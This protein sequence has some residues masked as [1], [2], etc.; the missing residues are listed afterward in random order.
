MTF[1]LRLDEGLRGRLEERAVLEGRS[2]ANLIER[3]L[4]LGLG[5]VVTER[6]G[7]LAATT[8]TPG[9]DEPLAA[10]S[11]ASRSVTSCANVRFHRPGTF[12]KQCGVVA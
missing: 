2:L 5:Q 4:E 8:G 10:G 11:V 7:H 6:D 12:C 9:L 1:S 3:L